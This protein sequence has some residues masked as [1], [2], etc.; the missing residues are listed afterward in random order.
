MSTKN[1]NHPLHARDRENGSFASNGTT[2]PKSTSS[3]NGHPLAEA[4]METD[5]DRCTQDMVIYVCT[6]GDN[7][8]R[9]I[10]LSKGDSWS[11]FFRK[12]QKKLEIPIA[13]VFNLHDEVKRLVDVVQGDV[14]RV[15]PAQNKPM[16]IES[17]SLTSKNLLRTRTLLTF[18]WMRF[19][20]L[21]SLQCVKGYFVHECTVRN[22]HGETL[23][24]KDE[25]NS[26][27][28]IIKRHSS[29]SS[30]SPTTLLSYILLCWQIRHPQFAH[31]NEAY[32]QNESRRQFAEDE[33]SKQKSATP[34]NPATLV[35]VMTRFS[36]NLEGLVEES[37]K[38]E[39]SFKVEDIITW[40][41]Q[42]LNFLAYLHGELKVAHGNLKLSNVLIDKDRNAYVS[43]I[44]IPSADPNARCFSMRNSYQ[45]GTFR[46][47]K[48]LLRMLSSY[49]SPEAYKDGI[50][51]EKGDIWA[52]GCILSE[53]V[54]VKRISDRLNNNVPFALSQGTITQTI[55]EVTMKHEP[56]GALAEFLLE[57]DASKR[58]CAVEALGKLRKEISANLKIQEFVPDYDERD[59]ANA[60]FLSRSND[61]P[62]LVTS[63]TN[64]QLV[65]GKEYAAGKLSEILAQ[66]KSKRLTMKNLFATNR[67]KVSGIS[68]LCD[69][70]L[71]GET[72]AQQHAAAAVRTTLLEDGME[73][74]LSFSDFEIIVAALTMGSVHTQ[75]HAAAAISNACFRGDECREHL[76]QAHGIGA[77]CAIISNSIT[78]R[79][80]LAHSLTIEACS[81]VRNACISHKGNQ[82]ALM[83]AQGVEL[84]IKVIQA[85]A[86]ASHAKEKKTLLHEM[87][88]GALRNACNQHSGNCMTFAKAMGM[89][90]M[91]SLIFSSRSVQIEVIC[92]IRN[93][94]IGYYE[95][96]NQLSSCGAFWNF[97]QIL[98]SHPDN[99]NICEE[100]V[101][102]IRYG[103]VGHN[104]NK[105]AAGEAGLIRLL[106]AK[107]LPGP[108]E[109][110]E[111]CKE[112]AAACLRI[113]C[114][115]SSDR[116]SGLMKCSGI[117]GLMLLVTSKSAALREEGI[118]AL[119]NACN[120]YSLNIDLLTSDDIE[121]I[122]KLDTRSQDKTTMTSMYAKSL[123][124]MIRNRSTNPCGSMCNTQE[125]SLL[126]RDSL[127][128]WCPRSSVV[129]ELTDS[130]LL[131]RRKFQNGRSWINKSKELPI[132]NQ[133]L[134]LF[135]SDGLKK[136]RSKSR[137]DIPERTS[138]YYE[139]RGVF[140]HARG[141]SVI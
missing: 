116:S 71:K 46:G 17:R 15:K 117:A 21:I 58:P 4:E 8:K 100:A 107:L 35:L 86:H 112:D 138:S 123:K 54:T 7:R 31:Y 57:Y 125:T 91:M 70:L 36:N 22:K 11:D 30:R 56:L 68:A 103:I 42:I 108:L 74:H 60:R 32:L 20:R 120:A 85:E 115:E 75:M 10:N 28:V 93:A 128:A 111:R 26:N 65:L 38:T 25:M 137:A 27:E 62:S 24:A 129:K 132:F 23:K 49:S 140:L 47:K 64:D 119:A 104:T 114:E 122:H 51:G 18:H 45:F 96:K 67:G 16:A 2:S 80:N 43:D 81:A 3:P 102:A 98:N 40:I 41:A 124:I 37:A 99:Q 127:T 73:N 131:G 106:A 72:N 48:S 79:S 133:K 33:K 82:D 19:M 90:A 97:A 109:G 29:H 66:E 14:L 61:I 87:V 34:Q 113:L 95:N 118:A 121:E 12:A 83:Q 1:L 141:Q 136:R 59:I 52:V 135:E 5:S 94:C 101:S 6:S 105:N 9:M 55:G 13:R 76:F 88:A 126:L 84:L 78:G 50:A 69:C 92:V 39:L 139:F 110:T 53:L 63:I 77:L 89:Q 44:A 134:R 130:P